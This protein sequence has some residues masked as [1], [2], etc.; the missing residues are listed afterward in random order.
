MTRSSRTVRV[1]YSLTKTPLARQHQNTRFVAS[2]RRVKAIP[3]DRFERSRYPLA[4]LELATHAM[5]G[6]AG[7]EYGAVDAFARVA[8]ALARNG[9]P[10]DLVAAAAQIPAD[11]IRHAEYALRMASLYAG[12]EVNV[13]MD[14]SAFEAPWNEPIDMEELDLMMLQLPTI[15]ETLAAALI[16]GCRR[17]ACDPVAKALFS[18]ITSDEVHHLRLG[19]YYF[20]WREPQWTRPQR[21]R[22]ADAAGEAI[23]AI[24]QQF[25][26][27][28]DAP[29]GSKRAAAALGVLDS[30]TQR[31]I[32]ARV[33]REELVPGLDGLGLGASHAW[34]SRPRPVA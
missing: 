15:S 18:T 12:Q 20:A 6:L 14:R 2:P 11:E 34:R 10:F 24:E 32:V 17:R 22:V 4:A 13:E 28:R 23:Q 33:L 27:G 25:W 3:W 21:Q 7:G 19:W 5:K 31:S 30:R 1:R 9:V 16:D 29:P 8:S 26:Y